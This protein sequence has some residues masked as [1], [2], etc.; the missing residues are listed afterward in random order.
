MGKDRNQEKYTKS[1]EYTK[2]NTRFSFITSTFSVII[3]L[4]FIFGG[5]YN[6]IDQYVRD[7]DY[8]NEITGLCFFIASMA[9]EI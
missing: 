3:S 7:F 8:S 2:S 6:V 5:I 9:S 4:S 1:Q